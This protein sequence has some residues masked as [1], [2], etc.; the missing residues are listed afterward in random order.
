VFLSLVEELKSKRSESIDEI[1]VN[2]ENSEK[3][4]DKDDKVLEQDVD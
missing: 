1:S 2:K 4:E 3:R